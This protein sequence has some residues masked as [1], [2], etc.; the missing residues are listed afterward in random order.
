M[1]LEGLPQ[2]TRGEIPGLNSAVCQGAGS[3]TDIL[4]TDEQ[5]KLQVRLSTDT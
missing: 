4:G 1:A 3:G 5:V 2:L